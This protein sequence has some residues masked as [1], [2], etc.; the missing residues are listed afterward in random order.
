MKYNFDLL[1]RPFP[2][3]TGNMTLWDDEYIASNVL[4]KHLD[5]NVDS[6][7]RK[8][9]TIIDAIQWI[10]K[11]FPLKGNILDIGCGPGLYAN[12]LSDSGFFYHGIDVSKYQIE[13]AINQ[14]KYQDNI[15]ETVDFRDLK[16][17]RCYDLV[18]MLYGIY[19]FYRFEDR[20]QLL[21]TVKHS[22]SPFGKVLVEV[23]TKNHY[24]KRSESQDWEYVEKDGFWSNKPYLEL[25]A[26]YKYESLGLILVQAAKVNDCINIWNSWIQTF[27]VENL[28]REFK[29]AGF[30]EFE[31]YSSCKG[32][33]YCEK[34]DVLCMIAR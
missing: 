7:S 16:L 14:S 3:Q 29:M 33:K 17:S 13:Y 31:V 10:N 5:K 22:L 21:K 27:S 18:L 28:Q 12:L 6:G 34:T 25:N 8:E 19:S 30:S 2:F 1:K 20:I 9:S 11:K 24:S 15:F 32:D 23:F 4:R 26:F